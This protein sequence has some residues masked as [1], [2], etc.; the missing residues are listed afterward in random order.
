[1]KPARIRPRLAA[2]VTAGALI[3]LAVPT[4]AV[5]A[6]AVI[7]DPG[8]HPITVF[9]ERD[10][11][12]AEGYAAGD[13]PTIQVL[14][15]GAVIGTASN[16]VPVA[17]V[18][19]VNHPGGGCWEG[20]TPDIRSG[21][22]I[23]V[24]TAPDVGDQTFVGN[25]TVTQPATKVDAGTVVM[26]GTAVAPGGGQLPADQLEARVVAAN[27]E[28]ALNGRRTLRASAPGAGDDGVIVYDGPGL[29]TWTATWTGLTGV[30]A[31]GLSDADRAV[32]ATNAESRGLWLGRDAAIGNEVTIFEYGAIGG[33][34]GPECT[35][36]LASGPTVPDLTAASDTGRFNTDNITRS[37]TPSFTGAAALPDATTVNLYIDG[38]A[39]GSASVAANGS[40]SITSNRT[41]TNGRHTVTA[42]EVSGGIETMS[43]G[44]L[45]FTVDTAGPVVTAKAPAVNSLM[46]SQTANVTATFNEAITGLGTASFTLKNSAGALLAAPVSWNATT[47]VATLNP[48]ATLVADRKHTATLTAGIT[49]IA[50][51]PI[52][53]NSWAFTTGPRP[54]VTAKSPAANATAV[55]RTANVT[56]T[57]S[58]NVIGVANGTFALRNAATGALVSY[59]VS[60]NATTRVATLNPNV[61]LAANTKYTATISTSIKDAA[62]NPLSGLSWSFTTGG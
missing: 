29:T 20:T 53:A 26:K 49:D 54:V 6:F 45:A 43:V 10:M 3:A 36:P 52:A 44:S 5:P 55:S 40:Y 59:A 15:G 62:G 22:V 13:R 34:A 25:V 42:G 57:I 61:T 41:L 24:L 7:S 21:D 17:G 12:S 11:V 27:Q 30:G 9:P 60:Y 39:S 32:S 23:R 48:S 28:F 1:M 46:V 38:V 16:L 47:R 51:N 35:A 18:V 8:T 58:E 14:R 37:T 2:A 33:P 19:E 56:A 31:D 4:A 50:G